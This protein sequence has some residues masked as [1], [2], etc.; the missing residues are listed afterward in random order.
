MIVVPLLELLLRC[1]MWMV[2]LLL[3]V[4][5]TGWIKNGYQQIKEWR[6]AWFYVQQ[7]IYRKFSDQ[8]HQSLFRLGIS[9]QS[10]ETREKLCYRKQM[11]H[12]CTSPGDCQ[13][14][15]YHPLPSEWSYR[16]HPP[17]TFIYHSLFLYINQ[18]AVAILC[19]DL[20]HSPP[21]NRW[22]ICFPG[23]L[24][25]EMKNVTAIVFNSR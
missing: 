16:D 2:D 9:V 25:I 10:R 6:M 13:A 23:L 22:L 18:Q 19:M 11:G 20:I 17:L 3:L 1:I 5:F 7:S 21:Y 4:C 15:H 24:D 12:L 14:Y 8:T